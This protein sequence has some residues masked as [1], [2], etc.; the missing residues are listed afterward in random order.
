[1]SERSSTSRLGSPELATGTSVLHR[2]SAKRVADYDYVDEH[3]TLRYR[4]VRYEPKDFRQCRPDG[5]GDWTW[6]LKGIAL[7]PY[8]A[9]DLLEAIANNRTVY[10]LEGEK[11]VEN[12]AKHG[13]VAT[14]NS[15]GAGEWTAAHSAYL[16]GADVV[17]VPHND[18]AGR[19]H[20]QAVAASLQ[21]IASRV[22]VLELPDLPEKGDLSNWFEAGGTVE[23]LWAL[24]GQAPGWRPP[25]EFDGA[26]ADR[27]VAQSD[28]GAQ[29]P[30]ARRAVRLRH[31]AGE[32]TR[33]RRGC[34]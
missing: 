27:G 6:N 23:Q 10:I 3:G 31:A 11:D 5:N 17:I 7:L 18:D 26:T 15:G 1:M 16:K 32:D 30:A 2:R 33:L 13:I 21:G 14:C 24:V 9:A 22:R 25:S 29:E 19:D 28:V 12:G 20:G 8:R 34:L 4:V